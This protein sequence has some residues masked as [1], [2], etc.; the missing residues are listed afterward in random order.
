[1]TS[2]LSTD[3]DPDQERVLSHRAGALLVTGGP[4][5]GK[6]TVLVERLA[7]LLEGG[8]DPERAALVVGSRR[9][10]QEAR[11]ALLAR[12][13][14]SLPELR[15]VTIHGIARHV[16]NARHA[17]LD[18]TEPP[19]LLPA[20][21]QFALVQELL[22]GQDPTEWPAYGHMLGMRAF[23]DEVRQ[24]LSRAQESLL[25]PDEVE[26]RAE[27]AGLTGWRE[28]ARFYREY[29]DV[30]DRQGVVDF[31][32]LLQRA[33]QVAGDG[34]PLLDHVLVDDYQDTTLAGEAIVRGLAPADLV[35][36]GDPEAHVFSFQGATDVPIRRFAE[37]FPG[38]EH[39]ELGTSHRAST[40]VAI[41]AWRAGHTSEEHAAAARELRRLHVQEGVAWADL[42]VVVRRQGTHVAG[43]LRAIDDA[44]VPR[45]VPER[46]LS[47]SAE[48]ATFPYVLALRWL[49]A[50]RER[51]E[52]L[53]EQV[54]TS[55][56]VGL[57]PA[58]VRGLTRAAQASHGTI[59]AAIDAIEGLSDAEGAALSATREVLAGA[60][61][62]ASRS[63]SECLRILWERLPCSVQ[64]VEESG[65]SA[66]ARTELDAVA[67]FAGVAAEAGASPDP[68]T[69]AFLA[70]LDA[71]EHGP[72]HGAS[73]RPRPDAVQ[74]LT[75]H[76]T[77]G[78]E[79]DTVVVVGAV[80][81]SFPSLTRPEPMFDLAALERPISRSQRN[82]ARLEDERRLFRLV[83]GR[84]RH[85]VVLVAADTHG[86][87]EAR[88]TRSRFADELGIAW[89]PAPEGPFEEPVS[90]R[91]AAATWR[92]ALADPG[93]PA[94]TRL[95][96]LEGLVALGADPSRWWFRREWTDT[97]RP[98]H[99]ELRLSYSKLSTLDNCELQHVL[100]D[101]LGLGRAA[102]YQAWVGKTVHRLIE[103]CETGV[104]P[105]QLDAILAEVDARWNQREFPSLAVSEAFRREV[106]ERM[107]PNWF[108]AFAGG[109][110][111]AVERPFE[112]ELDGAR[113][114]GVID[115]IGPLASGGT[116]ITDFKTGK[117]ENAGKP[118][119][120]LQLG[121]YWL[122]VQRCEDLAPFRPVRAV[123][124]AFVKGH[125][126]TPNEYFASVWQVGPAK[127][128][129]YQAAVRERLSELIARERALVASEV[130]RP[131]PYANCRFCDF[132]TLC[133]LYPEGSTPF[134]RADQVV[135][136]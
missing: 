93:A 34:G 8:A 86:A 73:G 82:R 72:G 28:L 118:G 37:R 29:Q 110:S 21:D 18:Y 46:G 11:T 66:E 75:A 15:V 10:R 25:G 16:L 80:E 24:F 7:R 40:P 42:A 55:V 49:V 91:E 113:I 74:V 36:A 39:V 51:R 117:P 97:G 58:T 102:G 87:G 3:P 1:M 106:R 126:R 99:D 125:W 56:L 132:K 88:S 131:N 62:V 122:A 69:Q 103:D 61:A 59:A 47:L 70:A 121:I 35:V 112:F 134:E 53:I 78:Q 96:A 85:R 77:A 116:R 83:L 44:G 114:V 92:Q 105:K 41:D 4:G 60:G 120:S 111:L 89:S 84:A 17:R 124:L 100:A 81:G 54:L 5:S 128:E 57:S 27:K 67:T 64:L 133:P 32:A 109:E 12:F 9:A 30:I 98:L 129:A 20:P 50:D 108:D 94:F 43:L 101:E 68:S 38:S 136:P 107:I 22:Q 71:G 119:E 48:P 135:R 127:E 26:E 33:A 45:V 130:Y 63:V 104:V 95:A 31:A 90:V 23:A 52:E 115:R 65:S 14:G 13:Q 6:T 79:L 19:E 123:E 76:A 2:P